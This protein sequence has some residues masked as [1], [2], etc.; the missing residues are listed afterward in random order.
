MNQD[1]WAAAQVERGKPRVYIQQFLDLKMPEEAYLKIAKELNLEKPFEED[2]AQLV[3]ET[4]LED[5]DDSSQ[6]DNVH[7]QRGD[8]M[9]MLMTVISFPFKQATYDKLQAAYVAK[10]ALSTSQD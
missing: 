6:C 4:F 3:M 8:G 10:K 9:V 2:G 5:L 7:I 1:R